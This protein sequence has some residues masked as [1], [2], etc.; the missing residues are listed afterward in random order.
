MIFF[1][2]F[3][4]KSLLASIE[5]DVENLEEGKIIAETKALLSDDSKVFV[6]FFFVY[7]II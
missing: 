4:L 2:L 7:H 1:L 3:F 6:S 5:S